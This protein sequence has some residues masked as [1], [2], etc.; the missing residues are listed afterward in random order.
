MRLCTQGMYHISSNRSP[1]LLFVQMISIP[2]FCWETWLVLETHLLFEHMVLI[3]IFRQ[4]ASA[5]APADCWMC[6]TG[7]AE[8]SG[9]L[10]QCMRNSLSV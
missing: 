6:L 4:S 2:G 1:W 7:A 3:P 5:A 8:P 10:Y 9:G